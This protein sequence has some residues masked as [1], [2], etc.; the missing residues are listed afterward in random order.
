LTRSRGNCSPISRGREP[1]SY[2]TLGRSLF[3][4]RQRSFGSQLGCGYLLRTLQSYP[5]VMLSDTFPSFIH[6]NC[7]GSD[8]SLISGTTS[9]TEVS[10]KEPLAIC[11]SIVH[12]Y[13]TRSRETGAFIWR[14]IDMELSR[15]D[16]EVSGFLHSVCYAIISLLCILLGFIFGDYDLLYEISSIL[17]RARR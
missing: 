5:K 11:K 17:F 3:A 15:L 9:D 10:L 1:I 13:F 12:L 14:T 7:F 2:I 6:Q 4:R 8:S 16:N